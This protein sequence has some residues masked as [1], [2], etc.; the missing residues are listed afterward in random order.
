MGNLLSTSIIKRRKT[1]KP[2]SVNSSN[3]RVRS[4]KRQN[5]STTSSKFSSSSSF[6]SK[7]AK[8]ISS[9]KSNSSNSSYHFIDGRRY[10]DNSSYHLP[11]DDKEIDRLTIQHYVARSIL[12]SNY[13][14]PV[15]IR[16]KNGAK[17]LDVGCGPGT[18]SLDM[19]SEYPNSEFF[20]IDISPMY[21]QEIKP[22]NVEFKEANL[23]EGLPFN[24]NT[25]DFVVIRNMVT[26]LSVDEW[27]N[28]VLQE[29]IRVCKPG[30]Y[31]ESTEFEIPGS[32]RG[33][34]STKLC[35]TWITTMRSK[36]IDLTISSRVEQLYNNHKPASLDRVTHLKR[37]V[38]IGAWGNQIGNAM[39]DDLIMLSKAVQP[40]MVPAWGI[41]NEQYDEY[42]E[43]VKR[44]FNEYK[45]SCNIH[46]VFG[47]KRSGGGG[48]NRV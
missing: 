10:L 20:G 12:R 40:M 3:R 33:P 4:H 29:L 21:P 47:R 16:L 2:T 46:V 15:E 28:K 31:I 39:A 14:A 24:D 13:C 26:A 32:N 41:T 37:Q 34:I 30:G 5:P 36:R 11:S 43:E 8:S 45:S 25:F 44:E 18:W 9:L 27:E 17:V 35:D 48:E 23:L 38:P 19:A 1:S 6:S 22:P 42:L 7:H